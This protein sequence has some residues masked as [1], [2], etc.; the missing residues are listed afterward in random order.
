MGILS[1][2]TPIL[3]VILAFS[4]I[5][6][7]IKGFMNGIARESIRF[8]TI[9]ISIVIACL[10][11]VGVCNNM[12]EKF[13]HETAV[14]VYNM[15][16]EN[17]PEAGEKLEWILDIDATSFRSVVA[18]PLGLV[19]SPF[20]FVVCFAILSGITKLL[21]ILICAI[22]GLT[23]KKNNIATR[24]CGLALGAIQGAVVVAMV[25]LP[26]LGVGDVLAETAAVL[27]DKADE[28]SGAAE[29]VTMYEQNIKPISESPAVKTLGFLGGHLV[30]D[31]ITTLEI[32]KEKLEMRDLLPDAARAYYGIAELD[33]CDFKNLTDE[34]K[35]S[36]NYVV[37]VLTSNKYFT[38]FVADALHALASAYRGGAIP[39][40]SE[41]ARIEQIISEVFIIFDG[42]QAN[43]V[44]DDIHTLLEAYY[45]LSDDGV[46]VTI[47]ADNAKG[48]DV[49]RALNKKDENGVTVVNKVV[50]KL[51]ENERTRPLVTLLVKVTVSALAGEMKGDAPTNPDGGNIPDGGDGGDGGSGNGE[52][53]PAPEV[54]L[55]E[56]YDDVKKGLN[57]VLQIDKDNM[58]KEE[59]ID[60]ASNVI[61]DALKD[62]GIEIEKGII[63]KM[64]AQIYEN[65]DQQFPTI[66]EGEELTEEQMNN[67]I[68]TYY[69]AYLQYHELLNGG[70]QGGTLPELP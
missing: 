31:Q 17:S 21:Q 38:Q 33:G 15:V 49:L 67:I 48:E 58:E 44:R 39:I 50:K 60:E 66:P 3:F 53:T 63:D 16:L 10:I 27:E 9:I 34:N 36:I 46:L 13:N 29:F 45:I 41:D 43:T 28:E 1:T 19:V 2:L 11:A 42:V 52:V 6:S 25:L 61:D 47:S 35:E 20:I 55:N 24:I 65:E 59:Y 4:V 7:A 62:H 70:G 40:E 26:V 18:I 8:G 54:D 56:T 69:D 64:A 32:E 57:T 12:I 37:D 22:C 68:L 51:N 30:Y 23:K 5:I 14:E